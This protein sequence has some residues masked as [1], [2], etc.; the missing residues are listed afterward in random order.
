MKAIYID[1]EEGAVQYGDRK[2][3]SISELIQEM[4]DTH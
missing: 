2:I 1:L 4:H 3:R